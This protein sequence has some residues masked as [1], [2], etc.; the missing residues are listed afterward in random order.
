MIMSKNKMKEIILI[1]AG[2]HAK[3]VVDILRLNGY[4]NILVFDDNLKGKFKG[5]NIVGKLEDLKNYIGYNAIIAIGNNNVRKEIAE[6]FNLNYV[7]CVHP[8][9]IIAEDVSIG[10]GTVIMANAII[11]SDSVVGKHCIINS[12]VIIEH[13]NELNNYVHVSPGAKLGGTVEI[14]SESWIGIGATVKNNIKITN[15][16]IIGAGATVVKDCLIEGIYI[17]T[18]AE[19]KGRI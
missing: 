9:A 12:G 19:K 1:G 18:P 6:N 16:V 17:G 2:G 4:S 13:D 11:N 15:N 3:V 14:G 10:E 5:L 8:S 7:S